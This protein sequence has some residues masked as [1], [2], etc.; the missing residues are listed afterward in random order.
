MYSDKTAKR[1][2]VILSRPA[3]P[4][5]DFSELD[6]VT[7]SSRELSR[8]LTHGVFLPLIAHDVLN[9]NLLHNSGDA[10]SGTVVTLLYNE[11]FK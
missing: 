2:V 6:A 5:F 3:A 4:S 10:R 1:F 11:P 7:R 8:H 9:I